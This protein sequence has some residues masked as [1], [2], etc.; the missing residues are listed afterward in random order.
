MIFIFEIPI[1]LIIICLLAIPVFAMNII[2]S[3]IS[4]FIMGVVAI[5]DLLCFIALISF[6]IKCNTERKAKKIGFFPFICSI[7]AIIVFFPS[8]IFFGES[9][10][11]DESNYFL[12]FLG[13]NIESKVSF[14]MGVAALC[15]A[16]PCLLSLISKK[17]ITK[18]FSVIIMYLSLFSIYFY[19]T[20]VCINSYV[21]YENKA[22]YTSVENYRSFQLDSKANIYAS[23]GSPSVM[24]P[25]LSPYKI[26][27]GKFDIGDTVYL[28]S[29]NNA[30]EYF[31]YVKVTDTK[32]TGYIEKSCLS[33]E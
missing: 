10:S 32:Q 24:F 17:Q 26:T 3:I 18:Y 27:I 33:Y 4:N 1:I 29:D 2:N 5:A 21:D 8:L 14:M 9:V 6:A 7:L 11:M 23:S 28:L 20:T 15:Y 31:D 19:S 16:L 22:D 13:P 30:L 12:T 25:L